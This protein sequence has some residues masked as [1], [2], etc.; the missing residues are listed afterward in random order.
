MHFERKKL[1]WPKKAIYFDLQK[2]LRKIIFRQIKSKNE[3][4]KND[5][6]NHRLPPLVDAN[7]G[8]P[9]EPRV[10]DEDASESSGA[11]EALEE[12]RVVVQTKSLAKPVH[13]VLLNLRGRFAAFDAVH[14]RIFGLLSYQPPLCSLRLIES[15]E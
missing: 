3:S 1:I 11:A 6:T 4:N 5:K 13:R 2:C 14:P 10:E 15:L 9:C 7:V 8:G 12:T